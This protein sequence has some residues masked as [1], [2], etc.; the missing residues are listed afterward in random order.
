MSR[1][2]LSYSA[3]RKRRAP[4]TP[5]RKRRQG[6][7]FKNDHAFGRPLTFPRSRM[8]FSSV[9]S[10]DAQCFT[11]SRLASCSGGSVPASSTKSAHPDTLV[12]RLVSWSERLAVLSN[13]EGARNT[14]R[15]TCAHPGKEWLNLPET[16]LKADQPAVLHCR[17]QAFRNTC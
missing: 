6:N 1:N 11:C 8:S 5:V 2:L 7:D 12:Y 4:I 16:S 14:D 9:S 13:G 3:A 17:I 15:R 10:S